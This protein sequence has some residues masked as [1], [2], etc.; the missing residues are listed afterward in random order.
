MTIQLRQDQFDLKAAAYASP[1]RN[2]LAVLPTGGGKSVVMADVANDHLNVEQVIAAHRQELTGQLSLAVARRGIKHRLIAPD[3]VIRTITAQ[4]RDEF[5]GYSYIN[6]SSNCSVGSVDTINARAEEL[7]QWAERVRLWQ[8]DEAHHILKENKWGKTVA[9][10]KNARGYGWTATPVRADGKGLGMHCE[11]VFGDMV[12]GPTMRELIRMGALCDYEIVCPTSDLKVDD[13]DIG[14]SGD[15]STKTLRTAA[16]K[17]RIVGDVVTSYI[18]HAYGKRGITFATDV[19]TAEE[20][21]TRFKLFGIPAACISSDSDD[22]YRVEMIKRFKRGEILQLVNVDLFGEGFDV[23]GVEVVSMARPTASLGVY[24]QQFGRA[25]RTLA[26]KL[27]GLVIDHVSNF[28]RHGPPDRSRYWTLDRRDKRASKA[29]D[30]EEVP[31][32]VCKA[33]S[34]PYERLFPACPYCGA[35]PPVNTVSRAIEIVEGDL[36]RLTRDEL[37]RMRQALELPA[38]GAAAHRAFF[39]SDVAGN[40]AKLRAQ[41][42]IAAQTELKDAIALWAGYERFKGRPDDQTYRRFYHATGVDVFTAQTLD[43]QAMEKLAGDVRRWMTRV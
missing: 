16:E 39:V 24:L 10:F 19:K 30:P 7:K 18:T 14:A 1:Q 25:L 8:M 33:C 27:F 23:P 43:K 12:Q 37:E 11:G 4:H 20:I 36:T 9:L 2:V 42:R 17:S 28:K 38:P 40:S 29:S 21:A 3:N 22:N 26:G 31:I 13:K 15:W 5:N 34:K 41:E 32:T 6:P 35:V